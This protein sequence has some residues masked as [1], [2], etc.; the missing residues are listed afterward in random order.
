[1]IQDTLPAEHRA[2]RR[3]LYAGQIFKRPPNEASLDLVDAALRVLR[4]VLGEP[5]RQAH[6]RLSP[7]AL[8]EGIGAAR[9]ALYLDETNQ[10]RVRAVMA[11]A[12]FDPQAVAFDPARVR[13]V[14]HDGHLNPRAAPVYYPHRDTWYG[15]PDALI[16]WWIPLFDLR[17]EETFV[18]Y[19][20]AFDRPVPNDSEVFDYTRWRAGGLAHRLGWQDYDT[21]LK[22]RYPGQT[23]QDRFDPGPAVGFDCRCGENLLFSG[24][25]FHATRPQSTGLTRF[26]LDF[27]VVHLGDFAEGLGAPRVDNRSGG[28]AL[29]DYIQPR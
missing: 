4:D 13:V 9:R 7:E 14:A 29:P 12:G 2:L 8:F 17:A 18:F 21:A 10:A 6:A 27:R 25:H 16:T 5:I 20:S 1:M 23:P 26:S 28:D 24:A 15:H 11:A 3:A 22:A 19:P